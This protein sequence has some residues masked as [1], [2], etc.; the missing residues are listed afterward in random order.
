MFPDFLGVGAQK[1]GTTWLYRNLQAHP[2]IW[3]PPIKELHY[4][5]E[6]AQLEDGLISRL[7]GAHPVDV[8]WR[9]QFRA[10]FR[11]PLERLTSQDL[12]WD[13]RYFFRTP[14]NGWYASLF[15]PGSGKVTGEMTPDYAILEKEGVA[16]VHGLMPEAKII[17]MMRNPIE[18]PWSVTNMGLRIRG[19]SMED[20]TIE[21]FRRQFERGRVRR[22]T[23]YLLTLDTW[24]S[25][26]SEER[27]FVGFLEDIHFF[28][29][30]TL[31]SL[32]RFL[33]V[34]PSAARGAIT[35][36]IHP[37]SAGE[38]PV[39][40]AIYLA[41]SYLEETRHLEER[42][43]GYASFWRF[44]AERLARRPPEKRKKKQLEYPLWESRLWKR[45]EGS[46]RISPQSGPLSSLPEA[47]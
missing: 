24:S 12:W 15:K 33:G 22:M 16:R 4:F 46:R 34:D 18:R 2:E 30:E 40:L 13:L 5:D 43:G 39:R 7:R 32:Y 3:M 47:S 44:C 29:E 27:I 38:M 19:R 37:G 1:A 6:K 42:F 31:R 36:K 26:Y 14:G 9:R 10:R 45:W 41:R 35:Q 28:P 21:K 23:D 20:M 11:H 8:R 17:F 25:F